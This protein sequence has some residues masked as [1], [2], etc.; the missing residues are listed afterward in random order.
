MKRLSEAAR[1]I[2]RTGFLLLMPH[3]GIPMPTLWEAIRGRRGGHPF[4]TWTEHADLMWDWKDEIP[5]KRLAYYGSIWAGV[6]GFVCLEHLPCLMKL[7][8]C[9]PGVEGFRVAYREGRLSFNGSRLCEALYHKGALNTYRLRVGTGINPGSFKRALTEL[10]R[11]L[12]IAKCGTDGKDTTW[13]AA[14]VDLAARVFPRADTEARAFSFME[15]RE[16]ALAVMAKCAPRLTERQ[17]AR[18]LHIG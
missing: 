1:F 15:A 4:T 17:V 5:A 14:V 18:L 9:P 8:G 12:L 2:D 6:P 3:R 10:Q 13:P 16:T 7:W 11:K